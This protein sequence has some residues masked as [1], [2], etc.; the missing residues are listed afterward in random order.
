MV[1]TSVYLHVVFLLECG[2]MA[3]MKDFILKQ[4][5]RDT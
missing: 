1:C 5:E 3:K 2:R 4:T